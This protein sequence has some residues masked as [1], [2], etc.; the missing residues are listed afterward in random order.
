ML[1]QEHPASQ[2]AIAVEHPV[3]ESSKESLQAEVISALQQAQLATKAGDWSAV[4]TACMRVIDQCSDIETNAQP[5]IQLSRRLTSRA[6]AQESSQES[7][8]ESSQQAIAGRTTAAMYQTKADILVEKGQLGDAVDALRLA[9][10]HQPRQVLLHQQIAALYARQQQ[11]QKAIQ[12]Y[13]QALKINPNDEGVKA[14]IADAWVKVARSCNQ[15]GDT[16]ESIRA[17]LESIRYQPRLYNAYN[18]LR[19]NLMRYDLAEGDPVLEEVVSVCQQIVEAS[20][21]LQ[22]AAVT[23]GYALTKLGKSRQAIECYRAISNHMPVR[24][25]SGRMTPRERSQVNFQPTPQLGLQSNAE[26]DIELLDQPLSPKFMV[27]G[28]EKCGTTS[29]YQYLFSHPQVLS[30]VEKEI[31]FFDLEYK[32][33]KAW[34]QAHFPAQFRVTA[35][36]QSKTLPSLQRAYITGETSANYLYS[37]TA[38]ARVFEYFPKIQL[39][40]VLRHPVDRTISRYNMMVRNGTEKRSFEAAIDAERALIEPALVGEASAAELWPLLNRARHIGNSLYYHHLC[41]WLNFFSRDQL[42]VLRSEDLFSA[43]EQTLKTICQ[44]LKIDGPPHQDYGRYNAGQYGA[45]SS[46]TRQQLF[47]F[48]EPQTR[49][50]ET[51]LGMTF[52]WVAQ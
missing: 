10:E 37:N 19:Y 22:A 4:V 40:V 41:R 14:H 26:T 1:S 30:P 6:E 29:L 11:W 35:A 20:P 17:Y 23:L 7:L 28:A 16:T 44:T 33:G 39:I 51:L 52:G 50:L 24:Q 49:K 34:Y 38:P 5:G 36:A 42:L 27:I 9:L 13:Q 3:G 47:N 25:L 15:T 45:V 43:P 31:D 48:F 2:A 46:E 8:Q 18:R 32:Q 12:Y 21:G